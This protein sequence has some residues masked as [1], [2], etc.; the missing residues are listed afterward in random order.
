MDFIKELGYL[1][2]AS[3][4]KRL[5][6]RF[7]RGGSQA[8]KSLNIDFEPRW[9]T[10]FYLIYTQ[11][12]PLSI[13]EIASSLKISHPGVI[14]TTQMLIKKGLIKSFQD[15]QDR[16]IRRLAKTKKGK[17]LLNFLIP[18]WNDFET[19]TSE[20]FN[21]AGVDML[22]II[23]KVEAQLDE[24]DVDSRIIN[25]IKQRQYDA[26]EIFD[27]TSKFKEYFQK[28]N[29]EWLEKYF[30]VEDLDRKI[31]FN[32]EEEIIL[33]GGHILF[34]RLGDE[35]VGTTAVLKRDE[36]TYEIAKMAVTEKAQGRQIGRKLTKK[37][38]ARAREK[39]A[40]RLVLKTDNRLR[41][42][43]NLYRSFGFK[44]M[45]TKPTASEK[46]ERER[47]GIQMKLD[48]ISE[49]VQS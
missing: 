13:S 12:A 26:I 29:Y 38:I 45:Q 46:Y 6:D 47:F 16:R 27:F 18:I 44:I 33:K 30:K 35:I 41:A 10:V 14:Q 7:M 36:K 37:A 22:D 19:A 11:T 5:T 24:E 28:L 40:K 3:R 15:C 49:E 8:Y 31:L 1:A 25:R 34:A 23:Q 4:M 20:L 21:K 48:L 2:I 39:G 17:E 43:L 42:A 9:F 32:P